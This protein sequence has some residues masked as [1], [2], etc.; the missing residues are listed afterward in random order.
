MFHLSRC[1]RY[2]KAARINCLSLRFKYSRSQYLIVMF[3]E[4]RENSSRYS[5]TDHG[6]E[7]IV[8]SNF[9]QSQKREGDV[10]PVAIEF[11]GS[12]DIREDPI[13]IMREAA[14]ALAHIHKA[15][16]M[17]RFMGRATGRLFHLK[18]DIQALPYC[19]LC[20]ESRLPPS[21]SPKHYSPSSFIS[22]TPFY[23]LPSLTT[24]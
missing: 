23:F 3:E 6:F 18:N 7:P 2:F 11:S 16:R 12:S 19:R 5:F 20:A 24:M 9:F 10:P 1:P 21:P 14:I 13:R 8:K 15:R 4:K 17:P 22:F